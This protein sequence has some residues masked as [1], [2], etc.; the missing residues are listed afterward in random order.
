M[1]TPMK[2]IYCLSVIALFAL[3]ACSPGPVVRLE[4]TQAVGSPFTASLTEEY[5]RLAASYGTA[6]YATGNAALF[7]RKGLAAADGVI[8]PPENVPT[9]DWSANA[10]EIEELALAR[11]DLMEALTW[12]RQMDPDTAATA[13]TRFDCWVAQ[14]AG[15]NTPS[16]R[17][18][19]LEAMRT[20]AS[21]AESIAGAPEA[22][23]APEPLSGNTV[24]GDSTG[25]SAFP[26]PISS[27]Y[28]AEAGSNRRATPNDQAM[29]L[30]FFDWNAA[31]LSAGAQDSIDAAAHEL[32]ERGAA[33]PIRITG[34]ADTSGSETYNERLS[35]M[36]AR[37]VE[38]ALAQRGIPK[39]RL[40]SEGRGERDL[41]VA[42]PDNV[43]EPSNR[44]AQITLE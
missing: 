39:N 15:G 43:R 30:V 13:Q 14:V 5:R 34:H 10:Q 22:R 16:C 2:N 20:L 33:G 23:P 3:S 24:N 28:R 31:S 32:K 42:T 12:G 26:P 4:R 44:R 1:L 21:D 29:F 35:I 19:F 8:A 41:M 36:R 38:E 11:T 17:I 27:G 7:A 37:T 18:A 40:T 9:N 6:V 25:A